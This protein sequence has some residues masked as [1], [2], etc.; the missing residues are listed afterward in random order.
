[1]SDST[2]SDSFQVA[3]DN[4]AAEPIHIPGSVQSFGCLLAV[5]PTTSE[6][7]Y[8]SENTFSFMDW[9]VD[10]V[11]GKPLRNLVGSEIWHDICNTAATLNDGTLAPNAKTVELNGKARTLSVSTSDALLLVEVEPDQDAA[12]LQSTS[13]KTMTF[14]V[15][16]LQSCSNE[17][18]LY[19]EVVKL[20]RNL[21]GYDRVM[22]YRFDK[23][24]NG[25][26]LAED[27]SRSM[28][29]FRGLRFPHWDIP[30]Q[31][32][33]MMRKSAIRV[34]ADVKQAPVL[35]R[36]DS[37]DAPPLDISLAT[38]RGVSPIH[39][40][41]L[42][43]M[44]VFGSMTLSIVVSGQLWG[45]ITF[46][47]ESA[48]IP[49]PLLRAMLANFGEFFAAKVQT[50][51]YDGQL[52]LL[53]RADRLIEETLRETDTGKDI[54]RVL[55][56]IA[57]KI[58]DIMDAHGVAALTTLRSF[59]HGDVPRKPLLDRLLE[60]GNAHSGD[61]LSFEN[62]S[63]EFP[64]LA[65]STNGCAGAL[66]AG[67]TPNRAICIFRQEQAQKIN[68]AGAPSKEL[69]T[70]APVARLSPRGSFATYME[71]IHGQCK[72]WSDKD[73]EFARRIWTL[74][75]GAE[76]RALDTLSRQQTIMI[77][78]LNH[79][80]RNILA[81]ISSV[82][83]Q[84]RERYGTVEDYS[85]SLEAR[86]Q[87]IATAHDIVS[88]GLA[89][90]VPIRMI[91]EKELQPYLEHQTKRAIIS[92]PD[93]YLRAD[94]APVFSLI[95]HELVT[96]AVKY[97]ALS[98]EAG[99]LSI[100]I[101]I[102][103]EKLILHWSESGGPPV[104]PPT[105]RGFGSTLIEQAVPHELRGKA[106]LKFLAGG[107]QADLAFPLSIFNEAASP[108]TPSNGSVQKPAGMYEVHDAL[109]DIGNQIALILEDNYI[110]AQGLAMQ[111]SELGIEDVEICSD[112][113]GA[114]AFLETERPSFAILDVNL[115]NGNTSEAVA[116]HLQQIDVPFLFV[117]GYGD[118]SDLTPNVRGAVRLTKPAPADD[119]VAALGKILGTEA[120]NADQDG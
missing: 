65:D 112:V 8:A 55:P 30:A 23:D 31:A 74:I 13:L 63:A 48:K 38:T 57:P 29:S 54:E 24:F 80:V 22:V 1:M 113:E 25:E 11:L 52:A 62:L 43:N 3:L 105:S 60:L 95:I 75:N 59:E 2:S 114:L 64:D 10:D 32:R 6:I 69:N 83:K 18:K 50:L 82:S 92:G 79:R 35:L 61:V 86:I 104:A 68:W 12:L 46:H 103:D 90:A 34:I 47:H 56:S 91:I 116:L 16:R 51:Q 39:M 14:L 110:I 36:A 67:T 108:S 21:S 33:D 41:Y 96:N 111:L 93:A 70:D 26:V 28:H 44:G 71:L 58:M 98:T 115:G 15:Q 120:Q 5:D 76:R 87:A 118:T 27:K 17:V 101:S 53:A 73:L 100:F 94:V 97:G 9:Q 42:A 81:L 88:S 89:T 37:Q 40:D 49:P 45:I 85:N 77:D 117:T 119:L 107:V 20:L 7:R 72:P 102:T 4:C 19:S 66:V 84:S 78:E 106:E 109:K 99:N